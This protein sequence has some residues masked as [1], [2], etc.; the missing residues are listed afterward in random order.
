M[1]DLFAIVTP[2]LE[3]V[4]WKELISLGFNPLSKETGGIRLKGNVRN[5]I[6]DK[7]TFQDYQPIVVK[8]WKIPCIGV[9]GITEKGRKKPGKIF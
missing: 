1:Y 8:V 5:H 3:S 4:S 9:F 7:L 2:G 6:S